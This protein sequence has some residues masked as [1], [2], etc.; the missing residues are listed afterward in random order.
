MAD[1]EG[2][3]LLYKLRPLTDRLPA[4]T[5][6]EGHVHFRTKMMWV[7]L[8]LI[9]YFVL[10]NVYLY[11]LDR[12]RIVDFFS[13]LRAILAGA[14]GSV[15]HLGIG[16]IVTG[17][18]IMQLFAGAKIINLDLTKDEDKA[19][20]QGTQKFLV[21]IMIFVEAIPQVFG[22]LTADPAFVA[23]LNGAPGFLA[24]HGDELAKTILVLQLFLG[25]YL[26][27]LMDEVVSKWG[28]GSG[29][30]LFIAAGVAQA[31]FTGTFN[32]M[33]SQSGPVSLSN[34]PAGAI[35]KTIYYLNQMPAQTI[36]STGYETILLQPP[37]PLIALVGTIAI[38]LVVA[39]AESV[40][41]EL[42]LAH[43]MARGARGR[44]PIRLIYASNIPVILIAAVLANVSMFSLLFWQHPEWPLIGHNW[45]IGAY[46]SPTDPIL[47]SNLG[48]STTTPVGGFAFYLST[49]NGLGD[50]LLPLVAPER[51]GGWFLAINKAWWQILLRL[52]VFLSV[53]ILGSILFAKFWI[54]TTNMGPQAVAEQIESS[55]LQIP[56]FRRDPR[57]LKRVLER[58][59]P[60]VTVIS[61]AAVGALAA[62]ADM[63]GTVGNA[64]GTG[65]LL[66]VGIFIQ[67]YEAIGREQM[68]E[69]HPLLRSFFGA[70]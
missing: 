50:W 18:I 70:E 34:P 37:N 61:G 41:I 67:L 3:S 69:M 15:M 32:W 19:V 43:G 30:S 24:G 55:G 53:F 29:I 64:S 2:K 35:P 42:P 20:Y 16:P 65:V 66:A 51:Y 39:Y 59:I 44:Y 36:A 62:T 1:E 60:T 68:M 9:L 28:I 33:P 23:R 6:P 8:I 17:S 58:Y 54:E 45:L 26:V 52:V 25:S 21:I 22:F 63:I 57:V 49:I 31:I 56:G 40:R 7:I 38:F 4:V 10:T 48:H 12:S 11:G 47:Q 5:R 46:L 27:F 13:S 14:Q